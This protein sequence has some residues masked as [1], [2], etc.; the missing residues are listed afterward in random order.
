MVIYSFSCLEI[1]IS[2]PCSMLL[3]S[4]FV[5][6]NFCKFFLSYFE[7]EAINLFSTMVK[8]T[9]IIIIIINQFNMLDRFVNRRLNVV[10][11]HQV[12]SCFKRL[13]GSIVAYILVTPS[14]YGAACKYSITKCKS[15]TIK[16]QKWEIRNKYMI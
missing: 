8:Q 14:L 9:V 12:K 15:F 11:I 10:C 7:L 2:L 6:L 1:V 3:I 5:T 16:E 13:I 4:G